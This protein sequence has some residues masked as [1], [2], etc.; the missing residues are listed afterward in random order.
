MGIAGF[1]HL[2]C[3]PRFGFEGLDQ[4]MG[5]WCPDLHKSLDTYRGKKK[6]I[7][8]VCTG[9]SHGTLGPRPSDSL[10]L[11]S[12]VSACRETTRMLFFLAADNKIAIS[13]VQV[14]R[15]R[16]G[17][18]ALIPRLFGTGVLSHRRYIFRAMVPSARSS[19]RPTLPSHPNSF[20]E[21]WDAM[22]LSAVRYS[23]RCCHARIDCISM[24]PYHLY[25]RRSFTVQ[26]RH[27]HFCF[28]CIPGVS[29]YRRTVLACTEGHQRLPV[30]V[31]ALVDVICGCHVFQ[32]N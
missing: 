22:R 24:S 4:G 19:F 5:R 21:E 32:V 14:W 20:Q 8:L 31:F 10:V 15:S 6:M 3:I 30:N 28:L 1:P 29:T 11:H 26:L 13:S 27:Y 7:S 23:V 12:T 9:R 18:A 17:C 16:S 2:F 25:C